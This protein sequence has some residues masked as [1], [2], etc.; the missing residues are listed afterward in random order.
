LFT[1]PGL[2]KFPKVV[3][4]GEAKSAKIGQVP[5]SAQAYGKCQAPTPSFLYGLK[6]F[7]PGVFT[8]GI[9]TSFFFL[10]LIFRPLVAHQ[11]QIP[12]FFSSPIRT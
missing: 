6:I 2:L 8:H 1:L 4:N 7:S 3:G 12:F 11:L 5:Y 9:V 10:S